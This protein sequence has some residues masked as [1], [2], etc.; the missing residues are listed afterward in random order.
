MINYF[1]LRKKFYAIYCIIITLVIFLFLCYTKVE[2]FLFINLHY[3]S[4]LDVFFYLITELGSTWTYLLVLL[5]SL[6]LSRRF[7][8]SLLFGLLISSVLAQGLKHFVFDDANRPLE[9][10][11]N[12]MVIHHLNISDALRFH[13]FPSGHSV[14]AFTLATLIMAFSVKRKF[15]LVL[16]LAAFLVAYSR[17]Y[18]GQHFVEDVVFGSFLGVFSGTL[19]AYV[20]RDKT[21]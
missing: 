7:T 20:F 10:F 13:S 19:A 5:V 4:V 2:L 11:K 21:T 14:S 15:D 16:L 17:V 1:V 9:Y 3:N 18:L 8:Y 12:T 6:F